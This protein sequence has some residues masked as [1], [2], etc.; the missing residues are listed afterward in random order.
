V[1]AFPYSAAVRLSRASVPVLASVIASFAAV[2]TLR[3]SS[4]SPSDGIGFLYVIP[5][6]IAA[7]VFG[8][9]GG[10]LVA[11]SACAGICAWVGLDSVDIGVVGVLTR[12]GVFLALGIFVGALVD[13][14]VSEESRSSQWFTLANDLLGEADLSGYFTRVNPAWTKLLGWTSEELISRPYIEL[15]HPGDVEQTIAA[16]AGLADGPSEI[17]NFEN[18]YCAR[19]GPWRWLL[20]SARSDGNRIY[21]V[22]KDITERKELEEQSTQLLAKV[23]AMARTDGL[24]G[25]ANR[26]AWDDEARRERAR[27]IRRGSPLSIAL[28]DLDRFK[29]LNDSSGHQ[30]GDELLRTAGQNWRIALRETDFLARIGGDEFGVLL[31]F[32]DTDAATRLA[33]RLADAL[34][35]GHTASIGV[36]TFDGREEISELVQRADEALYEAKRGGRNRAVAARSA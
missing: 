21:V 6:G 8:L 2:T 9:R 36:A 26:R 25:A 33:G 15:V 13:R 1:R 35:D 22:A 17:V 4:P 28:I 31:P 12:A 7:A 24:T 5:I 11:V 34:P 27:A 10:V 19:D 18:R 3:F 16:A 29:E 23:E 20:W 14:R 32:C 30:A